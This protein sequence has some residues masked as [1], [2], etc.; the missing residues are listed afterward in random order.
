MNF[1]KTVCMVALV[2]LTICLAFI[3]S[4]LVNSSKDV[5]FPPNISKCPDNY[6]MVYDEDGHFDRCMTTSNEVTSDCKEKA[7]TEDTKFSIPGI[8]PTSGACEKKKWAKNCMVDWD[9]LTN[10][11]EVCYSTNL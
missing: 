2:I 10:N 9:G 1:Y 5:Q 3:G 11:A 7:F 6:E 8:G 4:L